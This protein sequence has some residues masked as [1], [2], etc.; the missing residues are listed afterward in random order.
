VLTDKFDKNQSCVFLIKA[1]LV[2]VRS[3]D[4]LVWAQEKTGQRKWRHQL[5]YSIVE[6]TNRNGI[7]ITSQ[8]M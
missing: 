2:K 6:C 5:E 1:V 8:G 7:K 4:K 3:K